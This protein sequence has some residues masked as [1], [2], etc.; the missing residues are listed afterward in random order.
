MSTNQVG[1]FWPFA[2]KVIVLHT[3]TYIFFGIIF[4]HVNDYASTF[5]VAE[6]AEHMRPTTSRWVYLGP[7]FQPIRGLLYAIALFPF[8]K[9]ILE[10]RRGWLAL[11][12]LLLV[13]G[14]FSTSGPNTGS[15][16]G[17][18]Y[19]RTPILVHLRFSAEIYLQTLAFAW[20]LVAWDR[21]RAANTE[22]SGAASQGPL[23]DVLKGLAVG[24][25]SMVSFG[26]IGVIAAGVS[27]V[28]LEQLSKQTASQ[29]L[30]WTLALLNVGAAVSLGRRRVR[31]PFVDRRTVVGTVLGINL[32]L[33]LVSSFL[34]PDTGIAR[35][36]VV[37]N[38]IPAAV[39][40]GLIQLIWR[41]VAISPPLV[42]RTIDRDA[43]H[44]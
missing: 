3:L 19:T 39:V 17:I 41:P 13:V 42:S 14:I 27:D 22:G 12:I 10:M 38:L 8:R 18:V 36:T 30:G 6:G 32:A 23:Q 26:I 35:W 31:P 40:Y 34:L 28:P 29:V 16:E 20:L 33:P 5:G 9:T 2:G 44:V 7:L 4:F 25:G 24:I 37:L 43:R 15:I 11:W 21:K 1:N